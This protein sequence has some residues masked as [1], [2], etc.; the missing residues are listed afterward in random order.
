MTVSSRVN[1]NVNCAE[2][3]PYV[4]TGAPWQDPDDMT[5]GPKIGKLTWPHHERR[6]KGIY[7]H[8]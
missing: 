2:R 3:Y 7:V 6:H 1:L 8:T 5:T 4:V